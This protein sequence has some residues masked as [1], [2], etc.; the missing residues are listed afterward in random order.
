M[1][2]ICGCEVEEEVEVRGSDRVVGVELG[3][4]CVMPDRRECLGVGWGTM[5]VVGGG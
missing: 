1:D 2:L 5:E 4:V 3:I